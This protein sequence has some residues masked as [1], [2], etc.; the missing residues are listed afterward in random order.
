MKLEIASYE[1]TFD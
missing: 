1:Y